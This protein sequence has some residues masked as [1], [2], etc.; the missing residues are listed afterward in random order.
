MSLSTTGLR[1]I[2][3]I[4][5]G[6]VLAGALVF[7]ATALTLDFGGRLISRHQAGVLLHAQG[8]KVVAIDYDRRLPCPFMTSGWTF[9]ATRDGQLLAGGVCAGVNPFGS[10]V[11]ILPA[12]R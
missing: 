4:R 5:P 7:G 9:V 1:P 11:A 3:T 6:A 12:L 10:V 2:L 8:L